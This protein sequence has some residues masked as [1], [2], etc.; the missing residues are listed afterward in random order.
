MKQK[1]IGIIGSGKHGSRYANHILADVPGLRL[2]AI[3]RRSPAGERQAS[4][5][6][7]VCHRDWRALVSDPAVEAVICA[8][9]PALNIEIARACAAAG[10]P[11]L[12]EKPLALNTSEGREI[13][14][15]FQKSGTGCTIGQTLRFNT[16]INELRRQFTLVGRHYSFVASQRLEPSHL[17]WL[18]D[19]AQAGA[20]VLLHTAIHIF[21]AIRSITGEEVVRVRASTRRHHNP[22]LEDLA[23]IQLELTDGAVGLIE[24]SKVGPAR[25]GRLE[26]VGSGGIL[27]GDHVHGILE[28]ISEKGLTPLPLAQPGPTIPPLL[29]AWHRFLSGEGENPISAEEGLYALAISEAC[30]EAAE[31]D[32]WV[33]LMKN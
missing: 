15:L 31:K 3:S 26:F 16:V 18:E 21:D 25:S 22:N 19:P 32:D 29:Q 9:P 7:C 13:L 33:E 27:Q 10:K 28:F 12:V 17:E 2:T 8:T 24:A 23:S 20:G 11:L 4:Q 14:A 1:H 5:W 30:L 6:G